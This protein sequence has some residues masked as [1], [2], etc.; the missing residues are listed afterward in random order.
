V[1][2]PNATRF[3]L[4]PSRRFA[5]LIVVAH[6]AAGGALVVV[7]QN[8][9]LGWA[10]AALLT[11]LGIAAAR[12]RAL[13][14]GPGSIRGFALEGPGDISLELARGGQVSSRVRARRWVSAQIVVL[15]L[16]LPRRRT[17]LVTSDMLAPEAF[18][19]L[20]LWALWGQIPG[21]ASMPREPASS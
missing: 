14:R 2:A 10:L 1:S 21:V 5:L 20:R 19:R 16:A 11:L 4:S 18:R 6:V 9:V 17:L 13:L 12:D 8:A 15:P 3:R 7:L